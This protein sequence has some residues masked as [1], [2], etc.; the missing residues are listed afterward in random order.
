MTD[1]HQGLGNFEPAYPAL[2][3]L[4]TLRIESR[5]FELGTI[6]LSSLR[7]LE[8]VTRGLTRDN[9]TSLRAA[10]WSALERMILWLGDVG[11]H[12]CDVE[13]EDLDW[14]LAGDG[15]PA[16]RELGLCGREPRPLLERLIDAPILRQL[17]VL[18][19]AGRY[20]PPGDASWV[21]EH[22]SAFAH[23]DVLR[24]PGGAPS[25]RSSL[26]NVVIDGRFIPVYE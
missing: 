3:N 7:S 2:A 15:L 1:E 25:N 11:V 14:I 18:D 13:L 9:L 20:S 22:A 16:V 21:R 19:L 10:R 24:L 26:K 12:E 5:W 8:L 17:R 4:R 6:E 23:L